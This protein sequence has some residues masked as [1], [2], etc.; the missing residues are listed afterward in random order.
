MA[1]LDSGHPAHDAAYAQA[2]RDVAGNINGGEFVAG[3]G[4]PTVWVR[5]ASYAIDLGC[6]LAFPQVAQ[7]SLRSL[8]TA[9]GVW[10]QDRAA[11]FGGW[12]NL[13]DSI[14][15]AIGVWATHLSNPDLGFLRWGYEV[16]RASLARAERRVFD[17][18][19]FRG[20]AS[21]MESNSAYPPTYMFNGWAVGRTKALSTN[22]LYYRAYVLAGR[23]ATLL[24]QD[25]SGFAAKAAA[26]KD[27]VN[28]RL[29]LPGKGYYA[30][31]ENPFGRASGRMEGLGEALAVLWGVADDE[32]AAAIFKNTTITPHGLPCLW[33]RHLFWRWYTRRAEYYHNGMVWPF[34]QGYW[35]W[36]AA[37]RGAV[38][39]F[40]AELDHLS[41]LASRAETF[42]EFYRPHDGRPDGSA[43]QL[44][45][46]AGYLA[47]VHYGLFGMSIDVDGVRFQP[48]IPATFTSMRLRDFAYRLMTLDVQI[49]GNGTR[50]AS[51]RVDDVEQ[52]DHRVPGELTGRHRVTIRMA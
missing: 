38:D 34:A 19:L 6:G 17:G 1:S 24:G 12:P 31:Y 44:W 13:T 25:P 27:A 42:H 49:S 11:H 41:A 4:W 33:P 40:A 47:M 18:G 29:W 3:L 7:Q 9:D 28:Q 45:S 8:V 50:I 30:Y 5:D 39:V 14:V 15:G 37:S 46:A 35:A 10:A 26:L 2:M 16:T 36:A 48:A 43:R 52:Q 23:M 51:L 21:F 22:L 20:C 32:Q